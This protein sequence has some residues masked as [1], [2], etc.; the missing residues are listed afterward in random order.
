MEKYSLMLF[1]KYSLVYLIAI[2]RFLKVIGVSI[3][4]LIVEREDELV[5]S[6]SIS[7]MLL[8]A[9][10]L[11]L[12]N[13]TRYLYK[14]KVQELSVCDVWFSRLI[15]APFVLFYVILIS[16]INVDNI[17]VFC[18]VLL[19]TLEIFELEARAKSQVGVFLGKL[20]FII[21]AYFLCFIFSEFDLMIFA[22]PVS[23]LIYVYGLKNFNSSS[24]QISNIM[25]VFKVPSYNLLF[26]AF[27]SLTLGKIELIC[28]ELFSLDE[29]NNLAQLK[30]FSEGF[31]FIFNF[32]LFSFHEVIF[33][34]LAR[35]KHLIFLVTFLMLSVS[36]CFIYFVDDRVV[37][38][39][40]SYL[41]LM[42]SGSILVYYWVSLDKTFPPL[43]T[44]VVWFFYFL[45]LKEIGSPY[46]NYLL[47]FVFAVPVLFNFV[48]L[49]VYSPAFRRIKI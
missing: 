35:S 17:A 46:D 27:I 45:V 33:E 41:I 32:L 30:R 39:S 28:D 36:I 5:T 40:L 13:E 15:S 20:F 14:I 22:H 1:L 29:I 26:V 25:N 10:L 18:A 3:F 34:K 8:G 12:G 44:S 7:A 2:D 21:F 49:V 4:L 16:P 38:L 11:A 23:N 42:I 47:N 37:G 24:L 6:L 31:A 43:F 48:M 9:S 19:Y